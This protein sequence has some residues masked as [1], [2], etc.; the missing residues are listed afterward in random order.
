[1][2]RS[3]KRSILATAAKKFKAPPLGKAD[4]AKD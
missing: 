1:M 2:K 3:L 4:M